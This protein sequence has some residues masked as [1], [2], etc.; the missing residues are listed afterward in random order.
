M[1]RLAASVLMLMLVVGPASARTEG[2]LPVRAEL[3]SADLLWPK[4]PGAFVP[5]AA[6]VQR[7]PTEDELAWN[8]EHK[9]YLA[10]KA[11]PGDALDADRRNVLEDMN[12]REFLAL[13]EGNEVL[14]Q[15]GVYRGG[16]FYVGHVAI[17]EIEDGKIWIIEA[18]LK[19]GVTRKSYDDWLKERDGQVVWH[20]RLKGLAD[21]DGDKIVRQAKQALKKPFDFW[22]FDLDDD[23]G[24]YCSKLVWQSVYRSLGRAIDDDTNPKRRLW[25]SPK[26]ILGLKTIELLNDPGSYTIQ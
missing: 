11:E 12:Y 3:K 14:G 4:P 23:S 21:G 7:G 10:N 25:L 8:L 15:P 1:K 22:N 17:V 9:L 16:W 6:G 24:F 2:K 20:G 19:D 13:Y 18:V 26:Q 5:Y